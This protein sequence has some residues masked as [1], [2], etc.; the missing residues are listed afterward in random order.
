LTLVAALG[1]A[2]AVAAPAH[3]AAV[4]T[5]PHA[6]KLLINGKQ[7]RI[8]P[9]NGPDYYDPIKTSTLRVA[10]RWTGSLTGTGYK[11]VI[12]TTEPS[13]RTWRTCSTGTSCSVSKA[14]PI[15]KGQEFSWT[16]RILK[17][18]GRVTTIV[19]CFM[20]CLDRG[21]TPP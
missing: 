10:A 7:L 18:K 11:V 1:A 17:K 3:S 19:G 13:T 20:V 15:L 6:L 2:V 4:S 8:T 12:S 14:V 21:R 5:K 16:V 9:F